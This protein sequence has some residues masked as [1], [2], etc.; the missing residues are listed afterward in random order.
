MSFSSS[1]FLISGI[2]ERNVFY[3][4]LI[5]ILRVGVVLV[6]STWRFTQSY[7]LRDYTYPVDQE[8]V[9]SVRNLP[10]KNST[11]KRSSFSWWSRAKK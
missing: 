8:G 6:L 9:H 2:L 5:T 4:I 7:S 1:S 11:T 10:T 3:D